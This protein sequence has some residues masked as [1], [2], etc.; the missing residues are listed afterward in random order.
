[1]VFVPHHISKAV[2]FPKNLK[3]PKHGGDVLPVLR[4]ETTEDIAFAPLL[5]KCFRRT[6]ALVELKLHP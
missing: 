4:L 2:V 6:P 5:G 3:S 1:M